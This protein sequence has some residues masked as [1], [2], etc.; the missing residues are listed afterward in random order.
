MNHSESTSSD[1]TK[2]LTLDQLAL[3]DNSSDALGTTDLSLTDVQ[4]SPTSHF[5]SLLSGGFEDDEKAIIADKTLTRSEKQE[6][7]TQM[8]SR[9][10]SNGNVQRVKQ[11]WDTLGP[12]YVDLNAKD[13]DGTTPLISAACFG[14]ADVADY[15]LGV[16]CEVDAQ[17]KFG[18]TALMWATNNH[19]NSVV[20]L[21]LDHGAD[22]A[23][24]SAG[25]RTARDMAQHNAQTN[26]DQ[27]QKVYNLIVQSEGSTGESG[28]GTPQR[29]PPGSGDL[30]LGLSVRLGANP[31]HHSQSALMSPDGVEGAGSRPSGEWNESHDSSSGVT[32]AHLA[33][34]EWEA[35]AGISR[36][37]TRSNSLA[38]EVASTAADS[39]YRGPGNGMGNVGEG[40]NEFDWEQCRPDQM[41]VLSP[42]SVAKFLEMVVRDINPAIRLRPNPYEKFIPA[43]LL[44]LSMRFAFYFGTPDFFATFCDQALT[45]IT[46]RVKRNQNDT[47]LLAFWLSNCT[48]LLY[49]LKKDAKLVVASVEIQ[50]RLAEL[51]QE[52]YQLTVRSITSQMDQVLQP[53]MLE[54]EAI[55]ELFSTIQFEKRSTSRFG[56]PL[57]TAGGSS[58]KRRS[59]FNLTRSPPS[60]VPEY[61]PELPTLRRASSLAARRSSLRA[62]KLF[63]VR[64]PTTVVSPSPLSPTGPND[65]PETLSPKHITT[66][67][68]LTLGVVK[69]CGLHPGFAFSILCQLFYHAGAE[70]FNMI[71][72]TSNYCC[73]ARAMMVRMN[74]T[75]IEDW[76]RKRHL[77]VAS[78]NERHL[79]P[80]VQLLQLLQCFSQL[81]DL[82]AFMDLSAKLDRLNPLHYRLVADLYTYEVGEPHVAQDVNEYIHKVADDIE[83]MQRQAVTA[84]KS[85]GAE[86]ED[87]RADPREIQTRS[88]PPRS[89]RS[90]VVMSPDAA[91]PS[92]LQEFSLSPPTALDTSHVFD[93]S[94]RSPLSP[95][96]PSA[97]SPSHPSTGSSIGSPRTSRVAMDGWSPEKGA[98]QT[99]QLTR[100]QPPTPGQSHHRARH[101]LF[102]PSHLYR[103]PEKMTDFLDTDFLLPF[104]I[105]TPAELETWWL[106]GGSS[107]TDAH[108]VEQPGH[109]QGIIP[110]VPEEFLQELDKQIP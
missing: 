106:N 58:Q 6:R 99:I 55:P 15:L 2:G 108:G 93:R 13:E 27:A 79:G 28:L 71:L 69:S 63:P 67:L 68:S 52:I 59:I 30:G 94:S 4:V 7:I 38:D 91:I 57:G 81:Q 51:T 87:Y 37:S 31:D 60:E 65:P 3:E 95:D 44:F 50:G 20:R 104:A 42:G 62:S 54:Y 21:L 46:Q 109:P 19:H 26:D 53:A 70:L 18:W 34:S 47:A 82:P 90:T 24:K 17:D 85:W 73:R 78:L 92:K 5:L 25:G 9:F 88:L 103:N 45:E 23:T 12:E 49:Y 102:K 8:L 10:C 39:Y 1:I 96:S 32:A 97:T 98:G 40:E 72:L 29:R 77:P 84:R 86:A 89:H 56:L 33:G 41:Y 80:V 66:L 105:P 110:I 22:A 75:Q 11:L 76:T 43:N 83:A 16:G 14:H 74:L 36:R 107:Y 64:T 48:L 101:D 35:L 61:N 100:I